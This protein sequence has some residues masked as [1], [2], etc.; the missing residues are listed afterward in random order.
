[1]K[2]AKSDIL[3]LSNSKNLSLPKSFQRIKKSKNLQQR[4][5]KKSNSKQKKKQQKKS[6]LLYIL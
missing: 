5:N 2:E 6:Y 4:N 3:N 1:M